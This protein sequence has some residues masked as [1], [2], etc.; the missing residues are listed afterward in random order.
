MNPKMVIDS[1]S[2]SKTKDNVQEFRRISE[3]DDDLFLLLKR[4]LPEI[5]DLIKNLNDKEENNIQMFSQIKSEIKDLDTNLQLLSSKV[6]AKEEK[7]WYLNVK[8]LALIILILSVITL[9]GVNSAA[10]FIP[11]VINS[12]LPISPTVATSTIDK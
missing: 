6:D 11:N 9:A 10:K 4:D 5:K 2:D 12:S 1:H 3:Y 8:D 7:P